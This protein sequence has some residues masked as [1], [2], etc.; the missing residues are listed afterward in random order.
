MVL[1]NK[2]A[3]PIEVFGQWFSE[4]EKGEPRDFNAMTLATC[5]GDSLPSA[6]TV[7]LKGFD[8]DGFKFY[9]NRLSQKARDLSDNPNAELLFYWK[10][11]SRQVRISGNVDELGREESTKYFHMRPRESQIGAWASR[12]SSPIGD[13]RTLELRTEQ[14]AE[15]FSSQEIPLPDHWGGYVL[16]PLSIEFWVAGDFRLHRRTRFIRR[17]ASEAWSAEHLYP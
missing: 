4:A 2:D 17:N 14:Y 16:R 10:S 3:D 8:G 5:G 1:V 12:Q 7:L 15:K 6:R 13:Y 11:L 9:T